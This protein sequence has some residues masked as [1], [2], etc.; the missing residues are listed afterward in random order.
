MAKLSWSLPPY[1][2]QQCGEGMGQL[3]VGPS[4]LRVAVERCW[5]KKEEESHFRVSSSVTRH[6]H[7]RLPHHRGLTYLCLMQAPR[8]RPR[9]PSLPASSS[10]SCSF[11]GRRSRL[12]R[13]A[14][15]DAQ[16]GVRVGPRCLPW[17]TED[18]SMISPFSL[19][20]FAQARCLLSLPSS[21][22]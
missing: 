21:C 7:S 9:S 3:P 11:T 8:F 1:P 5:R 15:D 20:I 10:F 19:E 16:A 6:L 14:G 4:G 2:S 18:Q 12:W 22:S 17:K 13:E